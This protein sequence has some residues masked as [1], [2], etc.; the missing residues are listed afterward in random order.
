M[1]TAK[2][3]SN[4]QNMDLHAERG[5]GGAGGTRAEPSSL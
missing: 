3:A 4:K 2:V 5:A 1:K